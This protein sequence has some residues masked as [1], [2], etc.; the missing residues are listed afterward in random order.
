MRRKIQFHQL[1]TNKI[2]KI[3]VNYSTTATAAA[4]SSSHQSEQFNELIIKFTEHA[5][6]SEM[7]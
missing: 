5:Q 2:D 7:R 3:L 6:A 4:S 1:K